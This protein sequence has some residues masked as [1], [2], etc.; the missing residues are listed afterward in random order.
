MT[1]APRTYR[2]AARDR[3]G[4]L[5]GLQAGQ[6][7]ILGLGVLIAGGIFNL[8]APPAAVVGVLAGSSV[9]AFAPASDRPAYAW[10]P[11]IA[12][13]LV[14][15]R[16][17]RTWIATVPRFGRIDAQTAQPSWPP[18]LAGVEINEHDGWA[19]GHSLAVIHDRQNATA[20]SVLRVSGREFALI[21]RLEQERLLAEWGDALAAFSKERGAVRAVRWFE[22]SA[23]ADASAHL[24]WSR[25]VIGPR[26]DPAAVDHYLATVTQ[27]GPMATRHETLVTVTVGGVSG[28]GLRPRKGNGRTLVDT[29]RDEVRLLSGRLDAAGLAVD[30]PLTSADLAA[31]LRSR[32]DPFSISR[33]SAGSSTLA[34]LVG[35]APGSAGPMATRSSWTNVQIDG[36]FHA[37]FAITEWPRLEVPP[38]W[39]EPLLL[40]SGGTRTIAVHLEPVPPSRSQ[41]QIDRDATRL[42]VDAEQ[43]SR[44]GFRVGARHRRAESDVVARESEIVAGY[45][46]FEYCGI[47]AVAAASADELEWSCAEWEQM[48]A[49]AG[50][51]IRRLNGQHDASF[52][53]TLPVGIGP[54]ARSWE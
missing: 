1:S 4:W 13:W 12:G 31:V 39:M 25:K 52:A 36:A 45:A 6:C 50:L 28:R 41:R 24:R 43:R 37:C 53:C 44:S 30:R 38:N 47:I 3:S 22:W 11:V 26:A 14:G 33:P 10:V 27:A 42:V 48:A 20:T 54:A 2:F 18:F 32:L 15:G 21:D 17:G 40:H 51:Q 8:G 34:Q 19:T 7:I 49:H 23:P 5:L 29:L 35:I 9:A 46:E 16:R